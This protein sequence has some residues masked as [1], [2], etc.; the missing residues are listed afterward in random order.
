MTTPKKNASK[1]ARQVP[2]ATPVSVFYPPGAAV[3]RLFYEAGPESMPQVSP[4]E[5][6]HLAAAMGE[7]RDE[8][9][10]GRAWE[11]LH[12]SAL[13]AHR[14]GELRKGFIAKEKEDQKKRVA[15]CGFDPYRK[16]K[17]TW[18]EIRAAL[19]LNRAYMKLRDE[20]VK[21]LALEPFTEGKNKKGKCGGDEI[22]LAF[23][24]ERALAQHGMDLPVNEN[25]PPPRPEDVRR[26]FERIRNESPVAL[27]VELMTRGFVPWKTAL[28]KRN[29]EDAG[30]TIGRKNLPQRD[31]A[32]ITPAETRKLDRTAKKAQRPQ[33]KKK[34]P[35]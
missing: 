16:E 33:V 22:F 7:T 35:K 13:A 20:T 27:A 12:A 26:T 24:W 2:Q 9:G 23:S 6:A 29:Q 17:W 19:K 1:Q 32:A 18:E 15:L 10:A 31:E 34:R 14:K 3:M 30:K 25:R 28:G 21:A 5:L 8:A 11:F 4:L